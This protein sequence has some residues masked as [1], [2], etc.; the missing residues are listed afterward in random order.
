MQPAGQNTPRLASPPGK[1]FRTLQV[2]WVGAFEPCS[3]FGMRPILQTLR[4]SVPTKFLFRGL[5]PRVRPDFKLLFTGSSPRVRHDFYIFA[6]DAYC[7]HPIL[8]HRLLTRG[9]PAEARITIHDPTIGGERADAGAQTTEGKRSPPK[10]SE[11]QS[12]GEINNEPRSNRSWH[13]GTI[14]HRER[15]DVGART[16]E[17]KPSPSKGSEGHSKGEINNEPRSNRSWHCGTIHHRITEASEVIQYG[18][19]KIPLGAK[20]TNGTS[21][22]FPS[23]DFPFEAPNITFQPR[24]PSGPENSPPGASNFYHVPFLPTT[25]ASHSITFKGFLITPTLPREEVVTVREP[26]NRAQTPFHF[27]LLIGSR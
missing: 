24:G 9:L 20:M 10:G 6:S 27:L 23:S 16:T 5:S 7:R 8:A 1:T 3:S 22:P 25:S 11:G 19:L 26:F 14:H 17:G 2:N 12:K 13:C 18:T 21:G 15:A 4:G